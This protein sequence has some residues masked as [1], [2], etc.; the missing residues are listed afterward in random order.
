MP[1]V[2]IFRTERQKVSRKL[3]QTKRELEAC[4]D[5]KEKKKL[6]KALLEL[7]VDLSYILVRMP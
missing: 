2:H 6:E 3:N 7:R 1:C 4:T 5:K